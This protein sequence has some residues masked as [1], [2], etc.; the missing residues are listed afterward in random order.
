MQYERKK[1][2]IERLDYYYKV[3]NTTIL[4]KQNAASG[5]IPASVAITS[6][7]DYTDAWVRDNVYSIYA[8][9]GLALAYRRLDDDSGRTFELEHAV[10]KLMRGLLFAMMRQATKVEKFKKSQHILDA[11]HAKY[12]TETGATVVGDTDWGHLQIDATSLFLVALADM[13]TSGLHIVYTQDEVDFVQNLVFYIERAYRTPDF[14]I[15][16]R[17]DKTNNGQPEL[18][19]SS[20]GMAVAALKAINGVNL[21]GTRGGPASVIYVL[22]DELTRNATTLNSFLPRESNSKEIDGSVLSVIGFPA[23][24]VDDP[25]LIERTRREAKEKLEGKY[26]WKRFLRDGHQTSVEDTTRLHYNNSELKIF[27][28]IESEWPLFFTYLVLEGLFTGDDDQVEE[29]RDKLKHVVIDSSDW[30]PENP[31]APTYNVDDNGPTSRQHDSNTLHLPL[32][33][34]LYY[35][36]CDKIEAERAHPNSQERIPNDNTP[37]V[38]ALSL[39]ILG[40]LIYENLLSPSEM[41]PLGRRYNVQGQTRDTMTQIVLLAEDEELQ[42]ALATY[43]LETQTIS[44]ISQRFTILPPRALADVYHSLGHNTKLGLTGRPKR[45]VGVLGTSRL[46]RMEGHIYAFTPYFMD[47]EAFYLNADP[48]LLVSTFESELA[49][50]RD[51]WAFP[52]RPT[53]TVVLTKDMIMGNLNT[54]VAFPT[55]ASRKNLLNFFMNLRSGVCN[56]GV[57]V[58]LCRLAETLNTSNIASLD[59]LLEKAMDDWQNILT[60][61]QMEKGSCRRL[62][63][64]ENQTQASTPG[65]PGTPKRR[66]NSFH[67]KVLGTPL[68]KLHDEGYFQDIAAVLE[69]MDKNQ[70]VFRLKDHEAGSPK[71]TSEQPAV[72][73]TPPKVEIIN[74]QYDNSINDEPGT[75]T[76]SALSLT[77]GDRS[78]FN[79]AIASLKSSV[80]LYDQV[81][82]LHYLAS[83]ESIDYYIG[84]LQATIRTLL[85]EVYLKAVHLQYWSIARQASGLLRKVVPSLTINITDLVIR[86]KQISIGSGQHEYLISR[87]VGPDTVG[88][89]ISKHCTD[90]VREGPVV[91]EILIYLGGFIRSNPNMFDGIL[92]LRTHY[93]II[94][95]RE[96][97]RRI[98]DCNEEEAIEHLMQLSP[99]ELQSLLGTILSGPSLCKDADVL[100]RDRAA[101]LLMLNRA[102]ESRRSSI[103]ED[104]NE[105]VNSIKIHTKEVE[106]NNSND[107]DDRRDIPVNKQSPSV[108]IR[109][110]S[111]G[112]NAGNFAKVDING[113]TVMA[114]SRGVH[115]WAVTRQ[116]KMI[117]EQASFDTHIS[118]EESANFVKFI[119]WLKDDMVIVIVVRD[120]FTEHLTPEAIDLLEVLGSK[121]IRHV[122]Y[123]DSYV[124]ITQ[125]GDPESALEEHKSASDGPTDVLERQ[126]SLLNTQHNEAITEKNIHRLFPTSNGRWLRR[127][128]NDGALNRV[129]T[130]FFPQ[131]WTVLDKCHG[132]VIGDHCLPRDPTVFDKTPGE[133]NFALAVE[134]FLGWFADPAQ[135]QIA[136]EILSLTHKVITEQQ[137]VENGKMMQGNV[138]IP[139]IIEDAQATFWSTWV[140]KNKDQLKHLYIN[141]NSNKYFDYTDHK[142]LARHLF[143]DLPLDGQESTCTYLTKSLDHLLP[144]A[145]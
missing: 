21:F 7:G 144:K 140:E 19:S 25:A 6:H 54:S 89:M 96:E 105:M 48:D 3:I 77:L 106:E 93:I 67:G 92:R 81:D 142:E 36:P 80:N 102:L 1:Y 136:V 60:D 18:N 78:Q 90:D 145:Y 46:Y 20:I 2:I 109:A 63:F 100:V 83:C 22:P 124:L 91:Q 27:E 50:A 37:L 134:S 101:G 119:H 64:N 43:G 121:T 72:V 114:S 71:I 84:D 51:N 97:I 103:V 131:T 113:N 12:K 33:P 139:A 120:D 28:N 11:L 35:V 39:Y 26:G 30:D 9:Y 125:K 65:A 52:G 70:Q 38:W 141:K 111:A 4:S 73:M 98:N 57:R 5:L 34:E 133:F 123:R 47:N 86:Q 115:V 10:I 8:V 135:R 137:L 13:T 126:F 55:D 79:E 59:F 68:D 74:N 95:L 17:G 29:Y 31:K 99:F 116:D 41:D 88:E 16:E 127:R 129:P 56:N 42:S 69:N 138:D 82:L 45:P 94:A 62:G 118:F 23:F 110:Q 87:P 61:H 15:W 49:F 112:Y 128:M 104:M 130:D 143:Y 40:N 108:V 75:Y 53:L 14:G 58:R 24:A 117:L 107:D 122:K 32:V 85:E 44:Q 66:S 132:L 76:E